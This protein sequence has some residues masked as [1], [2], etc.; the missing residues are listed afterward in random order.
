MAIKFD[1]KKSAEKLSDFLQKT[2]EA[3]KNAAESVQKGAVALSEKVKEDSY[4]YRLVEKAGYKYYNQ[5]FPK[6]SFNKSR[7]CKE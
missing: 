2:S 4:Q 7:Q 5:I 3:S 6:L 1:T